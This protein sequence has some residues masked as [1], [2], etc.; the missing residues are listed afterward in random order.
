MRRRFPRWA[1][2]AAAAA[3]AACGPTTVDESVASTVADPEPTTTVAIDADRPLADT[4]DQLVVEVGRLPEQIVEDDGQ[5]ATLERVEALWAVAEPEI[6]ANDATDLF[7]FT[8]GLDL[9]RRGVEGRRPAD[10]SKGA[11]I[12]GDV[13]ADYLDR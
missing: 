12:L 7:N 11:R 6:R 8:Q 2:V 1:A 10:A 5:D 9:A 4:L 3:T 13:V